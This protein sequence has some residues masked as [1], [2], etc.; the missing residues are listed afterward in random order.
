M[1]KKKKSIWKRVLAIIMVGLGIIASVFLSIPGNKDQPISSQPGQPPDNGLPTQPPGDGH[2]GNP[3]D[4]EMPIPP[5]R[6]EL[7]D[8]EASSMNWGIN[9]YDDVK[10]EEEYTLV[11]FVKELM[12]NAKANS[13]IEIKYIVED[14]YISFDVKQGSSNKKYSYKLI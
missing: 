11:S 6:N 12:D 9:F 13:D 4:I 1:I 2:P 10:F 14:D 3:P 7:P 8:I 5:I